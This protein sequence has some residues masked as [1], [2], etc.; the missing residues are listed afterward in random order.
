MPWVRNRDFQI[1]CFLISLETEEI[2]SF[3]DL[4][5]MN[6]RIILGQPCLKVGFKA[7]AVRL[8]EGNRRSDVE[9]VKEV[10]DVEQDRMTSL[11]VIS[12]DQ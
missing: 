6:G 1:S 5:G 11:C 12:L 9:V 3:Y 2:F 7:N 10:R 4:Y 8:G